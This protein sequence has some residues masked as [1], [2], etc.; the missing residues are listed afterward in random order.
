M[1]T[2]NTGYNDNPEYN[3]YLL[4]TGVLAMVGGLL[5]S[6]LIALFWM[7]WVSA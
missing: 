4:I 2:G 5:I 6:S 1:E 3:P 7:L